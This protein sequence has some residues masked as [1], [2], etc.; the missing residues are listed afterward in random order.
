MIKKQ[1]GLQFVLLVIACITLMTLDHRTQYIDQSRN[2]LN[3]FTVPIHYLVDKP[4]NLIRHI[5]ATFSTQQQILEE[6]AKLRNS[7]LILEV[8]LQR[9]QALEEEN[10]EL[11]ALLGS[12]A[13]MVDQ[14]LVAK[15]LSLDMAPFIQQVVVDKGSEDGVYVGQP[16][17]DA[18]GVM[19]QVVSVGFSTSRV[20]L[21]SD[22]KS[23]VP[24]QTLNGSVR[25]LAVG[26]G[27]AGELALLHVP[28]TADLREGDLLI[29]SGLGQRYPTGYPVGVVRSMKIVP[30]Q[31]FVEVKFKPNAK[32][33]SSRQVVL[34]WPENQL[35]ECVVACRPLPF[36]LVLMLRT[37]SRKDLLITPCHFRQSQRLPLMG[38]R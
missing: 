26:L 37:G 1:L 12:T 27:F 4:V 2:I 10:N 32:I 3:Q 14:V 35:L 25:T 20:M 23:A 33:H 9:L 34:V 18:G 16:V 5:G 8:R 36:P 21:V 24:V 29:T 28:V 19:G 38:S 15:V 7:Q 31:R 11:R 22:I 30:G 6:N 17:L 13:E